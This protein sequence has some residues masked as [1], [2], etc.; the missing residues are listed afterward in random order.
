MSTSVR[1]RIGDCEI[2][3]EG[4]DVRG[5]MD[6]FWRLVKERHGVPVI[7]QATVRTNR[8]AECPQCGKNVAVCRNGYTFTHL[9][10]DGIRHSQFVLNDLGA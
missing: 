3:V 10:R 8:R 4:D 6:L 9:G 7:R 2:F 1:V 5:A